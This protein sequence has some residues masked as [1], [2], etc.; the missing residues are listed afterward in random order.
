[1]GNPF[2]WQPSKTYI[3]ANIVGNGDVH[4]PAKFGPKI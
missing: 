4:N 2:F 3:V 1:M